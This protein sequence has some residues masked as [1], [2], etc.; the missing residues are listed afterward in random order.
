[1]RNF[2]DCI[3]AGLMPQSKPIEME[4]NM[5]DNEKLEME[6]KEYKKKMNGSTACRL[7]VL[8]LLK[9]RGKFSGRL[10]ENIIGLIDHNTLIKM[11]YEK[12]MIYHSALALLGTLN[13]MWDA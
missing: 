6:I 8:Q 12:I 7:L 3:N 4:Q 10:L 2:F 1:M 5:T 9:E 13:Y 11:L